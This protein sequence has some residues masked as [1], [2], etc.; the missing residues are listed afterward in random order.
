MYEIL[1]IDVIGLIYKPREIARKVI[2]SMENDP[3]YDGCSDGL[4]RSINRTE[5]TMYSVNQLMPLSVFRKLK[6]NLT[7]KLELR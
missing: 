7:L 2:A 6:E 4:H 3:N 1:L 5:T